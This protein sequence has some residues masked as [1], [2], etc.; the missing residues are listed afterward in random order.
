MNA[1][2][3]AQQ[4]L[5]EFSGE[6]FL[7]ITTTVN[8]GNP[9]IYKARTKIF[10][11]QMVVHYLVKNERDVALLIENFEKHVS[12]IVIDSESK[13]GFRPK[14]TSVSVPILKVKPNDY[15]VDSLVQLALG[16][17]DRPLKIGILGSGNIGCKS[18]LALSECGHKVSLFS[19]DSSKAKKIIE[20]LRSF[21]HASETEL[22]FSNTLQEVVQSS[23]II[24]LTGP[25]TILID[26]NNFSSFEHI[27][28][29]IDVGGG[30]IKPELISQF[31]EV[32]KRLYSLDSTPGLMG[33]LITA[34]INYIKIHHK[35]NMEGMVPVGELGALGQPLYD[36]LVVPARVIGICDGKGGITKN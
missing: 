7:L 22:S 2:H 4:E 35:N 1:F 9:D 13:I 34:K 17:G 3:S 23:E 18:A 14:V 27:K 25:G 36:P 21:A 24:I 11:N 16:L 5:Q 30:G 33:A 15:T 12:W 29:I 26:E 6:K 19:R 28:V 10:E 20:G 32:G 31:K 8:P